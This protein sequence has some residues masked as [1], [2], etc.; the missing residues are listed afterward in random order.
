MPALASPLSVSPLSLSF[1]LPP[2]HCS[3]LPRA[4]LAFSQ[5]SPSLTLPALIFFLSCSSSLCLSPP[6]S[7]L[8]LSFY[9]LFPCILTLSLHSF[10]L[11]LLSFSPFPPPSLSFPLLHVTAPITPPSASR[12]HG[13]R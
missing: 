1:S 3:L 7:I 9:S 6:S 8:A 12:F 5:L 4:F 10:Q 13:H 2:S 11:P